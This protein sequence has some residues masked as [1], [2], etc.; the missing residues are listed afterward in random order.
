VS[1]GKDVNG[2]RIRKLFLAHE[3]VPGAYRGQKW[4]I[5]KTGPKGEK[6]GRREGQ[7]IEKPRRFPVE[8]IVLSI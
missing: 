1:I 7:G 2:L 4:K 3:R 6:S 8:R 5:E